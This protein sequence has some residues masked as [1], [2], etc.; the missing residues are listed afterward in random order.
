MTPEKFAKIVHRLDLTYAS[1]GKHLT[2]IVDRESLLAW[3]AG[4]RRIPQG[5]AAQVLALSAAFESERLRLLDEILAEG[6]RQSYR[7]YYRNNQEF[8]QY[9]PESFKILGG[10]CLYRRILSTLIDEIQDVKSVINEQGQAE[11]YYSLHVMPLH[12]REYGDW[13]EHVKLKHSRE[14]LNLWAEI[15]SKRYDQRVR[16]GEA[17]FSPKQKEK[18]RQLWQEVQKDIG[19]PEARK[20]IKHIPIP[21]IDERLLPGESPG[22]RFARVLKEYVR[23]VQSKKDDSVD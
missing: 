20:R 19:V 11:G 23:L 17:F 15:A 7:V 3:R 22:D 12:P 8:K 1:F 6:R 4:S 21:K 10:S 9:E 16:S 2:P 13:L 5:Y 14:T 18:M